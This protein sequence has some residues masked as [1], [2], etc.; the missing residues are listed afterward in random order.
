MFRGRKF[1][2][3]VLVEGIQS[4]TE[5]LYMPHS[6]HHAV[7]NLDET[8]AVGDNLLFST[9]IEEAAFELYH[10]KNTEF[11]HISKLVHGG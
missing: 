5:T 10:K 3:N 2:G 7:Y 6:T 9:A 8:I 1:Y 4:P 11:T